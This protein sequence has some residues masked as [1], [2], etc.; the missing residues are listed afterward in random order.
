MIIEIDIVRVF[1][2]MLA[3]G[4]AMGVFYI[5]S[6]FKNLTAFDM[7]VGFFGFSISIFI[8]IFCAY[9]IYPSFKQ[10]M[11]EAALKRRERMR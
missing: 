8:Y 4:M 2:I 5:S 9:L 1:M 6:N 11:L 3:I 7:L 10:S